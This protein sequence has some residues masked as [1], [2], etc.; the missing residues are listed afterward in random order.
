MFHILPHIG[1]KLIDSVFTKH[2][3]D[4]VHRWRT[5]PLESTGAPMAPR[6]VRN[7][8]SVL[9]SML[10]DAAM[11]G[12]I[13]SSPCILDER[14]LGP[15]IDRDP[16]WR[17]SAVFDREE[18]EIL[19]SHPDIPLDRRLYYGCMLLA[20]MR[21]G[22][23]AALRVRHYESKIEPLGR[24]T[25]AL[26]LNTRKMT[27]KGTKTNAVR[28]VPVHG[29]LAALLGEWLLS[30]Y[31]AMTG[32]QPE[33]DD[34]L[35]PLPQDAIAVRRSRREGEPIRTGDYAGKC[36][37][38]RDLPMLGWRAREM[39]AMKSTF[40]TLCGKDRANRDAIKRVTHTTAKRDAFDGYDRDS[41]WEEMCE[42]VAKLQLQRRHVGAKVIAIK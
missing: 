5:T 39:Y 13:D 11:D 4:L 31:A 3:A 27:I 7:A 22:E 16:E 37:R 8:Y 21:P 28:E 32:R 25:V 23:I 41:H 20:G 6:T 1:D 42:A 19:I 10:R 36:W 17:R 35:L 40:I 26:A 18:A 30:G 14:Q 38:E 15:V 24:L 33:P 9:S 12:V 29:T 34:L 2:V